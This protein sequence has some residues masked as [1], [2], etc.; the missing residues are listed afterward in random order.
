M[1]ILSS[2]EFGILHLSISRLQKRNAINADMFDTLTDTLSHAAKDDTV[3]VVLLQGE[4]PIFSAGADLEEMKSS[5]EELDRAMSTFFS[6]LRTFPKPIVAKIKGPCVG[7]AFI[8]LLY[9]DLVYASDK[10]LFSLPSVALGRTSRFG[11]AA[12]MAASAGITQAAEKLMLSEPIT[13]EEALSMRLITAK[14]DD[15]SLDQLVANKVAR[16]TVLPPQAVQSTKMLLCTSRNQL[17][18]QYLETEET[19]WRRQAQSGEA[20][21]ALAAFLEGRKPIFR[22]DE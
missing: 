15:L 22:H 6:V 12:I 5:P 21:E 1:A 18:D 10:A 9:C 20:A 7:E 17:L 2:T 19:V 4:E 3:R 8:M 13:A 16:L 14:V 11:A